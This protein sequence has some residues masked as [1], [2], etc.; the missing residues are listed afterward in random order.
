MVTSAASLD[1]F[2]ATSGEGLDVAL[3]R[4]EVAR[5]GDSYHPDPLNDFFCGFMNRLEGY[6]GD[7]SHID[8]CTTDHPDHKTIT[9]PVCN[10][11]VYVG[12]QC[13]NC[14]KDALSE[15]ETLQLRGV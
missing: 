9:C 4:S 5:I 1:V 3:I 13:L 2:L 15:S 8:G 14:A 6:P 12:S 11:R 10:H 7:I